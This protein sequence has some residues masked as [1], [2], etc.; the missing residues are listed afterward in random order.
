MR[1]HPEAHAA[2]DLLAQRGQVGGDGVQF[3][4]D[5]P[6]PRLDGL[7][8][9]CEQARLAVDQLDPELA[10]EA[11]DVARDVGLNGVEGSWPHP[12]SCRWS[13]IATRAASW[14]RSTRPVSRSTLGSRQT[15]R[16]AAL[17]D[18]GRG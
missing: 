16:Q 4:L 18:G 5:G 14:R 10:L 1:D 11:L 9:L 15:W 17:R 3:G 7:A 8:F 13:A 12:R 2:D 6:C